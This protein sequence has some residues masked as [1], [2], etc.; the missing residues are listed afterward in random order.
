ML[1]VRLVDHSQSVV[2]DRHSDSHPCYP[3]VPDLRFPAD[4]KSRSRQQASRTAL[5]R[6]RSHGSAPTMLSRIVPF[7]SQGC[8]AQKAIDSLPKGFFSCSFPH[9][10]S[11]A[12]IVTGN[13]DVTGCSS[14]SRAWRKV[15]YRALPTGPATAV[16]LPR[17]MLMSTPCRARVLEMLQ[18]KSCFSIEIVSSLWA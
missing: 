12:P 5:Y 14:P 8:W 7:S 13:E 1:Q 16:M 18:A 15:D 6:F 10:F 9:G 3:R 17:L 4:E 11:P 2:F